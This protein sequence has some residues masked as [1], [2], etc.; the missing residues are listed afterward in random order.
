MKSDPWICVLAS[1]VL[2]CDVGMADQVTL[3]NGD[4]LTG[5][6]VKSDGKNLIIKYYD[7]S[8]S[9]PWEQVDA[10]SSSGPLYLTLKGGQ[11]VNG[12]VVLIDGKVEVE[13]TEA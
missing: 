9:V 8:V 6:I 12:T 2:F 10:I 3:K 5:A 4:R 7:G 11:V 13:T 1:V